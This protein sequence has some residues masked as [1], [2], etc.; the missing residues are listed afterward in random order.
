MELTEEQ[1]DFVREQER[2]D[3][4]EIALRYRRPDLPLLLAQ[5]GGRQRAL[6]KIPSWHNNENIVYP[7]HLS[8][9]QAS[10]EVTARY[11]ASLIR[12]SLT[13]SFSCNE[14]NP[15]PG[16]F[17]DLT[18]GLGVDFS[19]ICPLFSTADYVESEE[20]LC[21]VAEHNFRILGLSHA[22]VHCDE[23][24]HFL[25]QSEHFDWLY[26]D[27]SRRD[28]R[29]NRVFRMEECAPDVPAMVSLLFDKADR[30]MVKYSPMLDI[31]MAMEKLRM[32]S[33]VHVVAVENDCK[34]L[35]FLLSSKESEYREP[36]ITAVNLKKKG[37]DEHFLFTYTEERA[38][39]VEYAEVPENYLY[40]PNSA[41]LKA[42]AFRVVAERY[43]LKKLHPDSHLYTSDR[44]VRGFPG[45]SFV[46][47]NHFVPNKR[48]VKSFVG[49]VTQVN[50]TIRN[51]P[52]SVATIRRRS[53]LQ[54]GGSIYLFATTLSGGQKIWIVA[55]RIF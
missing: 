22:S 8:L 34:E 10:S 19:F 49:V 51:Y 53:G 6:R 46:I 38:A 21:R 24:E 15:D 52:E 33:A 25:R 18:G 39:R 23:A 5:I 26:L 1:I 31:S 50:I 55:E 44:L 16:S 37:S 7:P 43:G 30:V 3:L 4:R 29:G 14:D 2:N 32:V 45:R 9:E 47:K 11:K 12:Q 54:D 40:E 28:S 42:G 41:L 48:N 36:E 20:E 35:L 27:P 13:L 17:A